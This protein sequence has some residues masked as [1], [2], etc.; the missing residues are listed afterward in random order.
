M[1]LCLPSIKVLY[2]VIQSKNYF[3]ACALFQFRFVSHHLKFFS[4]IVK[5][6]LLKGLLFQRDPTCYRIDVQLKC[7][8]NF[9]DMFDIIRQ[10]IEFG[11]HPNTKYLF[12]N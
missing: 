10:L 6:G 2:F 1:L 3:S 7:G 4:L 11:A 9:E 5:N 12:N 8:G